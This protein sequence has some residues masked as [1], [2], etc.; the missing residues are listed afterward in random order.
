MFVDAGPAD[1]F[2]LLGPLPEDVEISA[3]LSGSFDFLHLFVQQKPRL[4]QRLPKLQAALKPDGALWISWPKGG[5]KLPTDLNGNSV[6]EAGLAAGL[7]DIKVCAVDADWSG[8]KFVIPVA[9]RPK[10]APTKT[11][12]SKATKAGSPDRGKSAPAKKR[13]KSQ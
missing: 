7:V 2:A 4:L 10:P 3:R 6:R 1:Y 8:L 13:P 11:A 12:K 9:K 5:S